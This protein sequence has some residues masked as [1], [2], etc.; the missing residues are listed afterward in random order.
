[1]KKAIVI[2][3]SIML[4]MAITFPAV[5][6]SSVTVK[7]IKLDKSSITLK[8]G[9]TINLK[10]AFTP[11]NTTQ[12]LLTYVSGNKKIAT[13]N[14]AGK[15]TGIS[16]G[17][18]TIT[19]FSS[20]NKKILAKCNVII[21]QVIPK[22]NFVKLSWYLPPPNGDL[23]NKNS[24]MAEVNKILKEK[25]NTE[26]DFEFLDWN[27][28]QDKMN[29][30]SASGEHWDLAMSTSWIFN[31]TSNVNK[32]VIQPLDDLLNKYGQN[33]LKLVP[34]KYWP[35]VTYN[36]KRYAIID[37]GPYQSLNG[38]TVQKDLAD[39]YKLDVKKIKTLKDI[40]PFLAEI[41]KNEDGIIPFE[42]CATDFPMNVQSIYDK[43]NQWLLFDT[44]DGQIKSQLD[45]SYFVESYKTLGSFYKS[46]YIA[47]DASLKK[48]YAAEA[49]SKKY[50]V[51][52]CAGTVT[53]D[54]SKD[55]SVLG[56]PCTDINLGLANVIGTGTVQ[57]TAT[58][59]GKNSKNPVRA[60]MLVDL[61]HSDKKLFNTMCYGLEGQD[62]KVVSG[63]G[64]DNPTVQS[65]DPMKWVIWHSWIGDLVHNQWPSNFN[66]AKALASFKAIND[67]TG[68]VSPILGFTFNPETVKTEVG[69]ID[70]IYNQ[71]TPILNTGSAPDV[72]KY[73]AETKAK[74]EQAGLSKVITEVKKQLAAWKKSNGK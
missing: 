65:S 62:Y 15:I 45:A 14:A 37:Y 42:A 1:M 38:A 21:S 53:D 12:K 61:M 63:A 27:S 58:A 66:D 74:M 8:V 43:L 49:K 2:I 6:F 7:G 32:G 34:E 36:G 39:K 4:T 13:I 73:I 48:D 67:S 69:Q 5:A 51:M 24:V 30:M 28:Y 70:A 17:T 54:S 57:N 50:A 10:V 23:S 22:L 35:A 29:L 33:I 46:G 25:I 31:I 72:E 44:T 11:A 55:T 60:M 19:V 71:A 47:K 56:F 59:I 20:S 18:T 68:K 40:E 3:L 64:T 41:K 26:L 9:Q 16:A 52:V